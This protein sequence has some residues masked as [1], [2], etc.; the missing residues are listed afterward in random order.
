MFVILKFYFLVSLIILFNLIKFQKHIAGLWLAS[1]LIINNFDIPKIKFFLI[2]NY[3]PFLISGMIFYLARREGWD[4]Y[5]YFILFVSFI[6]SQFLV[7]TGIFKF[8]QHYSTNL[9]EYFIFVIILF[10][11]I[12]MFAST[13]IKKNIVMQ[14][15]ITTLSVST[16]PLY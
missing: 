3:A 8:N 15:S 2:S 12:Y 10:I 5:K 4:T 6:Y 14:K 11:Y 9:S 13:L 7:N 1:S 16:Y